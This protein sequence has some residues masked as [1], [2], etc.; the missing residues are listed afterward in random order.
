MLCIFLFFPHSVLFHLYTQDVPCPRMSPLP[1]RLLPLTCHRCEETQKSCMCR[2]KEN[3]KENHMSWGDNLSSGWTGWRCD[4][5]S[6]NVAGHRSDRS[7]ELSIFTSCSQQQVSATIATL[8]G[9]S[10]ERGLLRSGNELIKSGIY[11]KGKSRRQRCSVQ[12]FPHLLPPRAASVY[13]EVVLEMLRLTSP[14]DRLGS[15][16]QV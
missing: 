13:T 6:P 2:E 10:G 9:E 5:D 1:G 12:I 11:W 7:A 3:L 15:R 8:L 4:Q 16:E 14:G